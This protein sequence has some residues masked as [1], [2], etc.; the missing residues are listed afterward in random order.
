MLQDEVEGMI[1]RLRLELCDLGI[2]T[3]LPVTDLGTK[4]SMSW[5]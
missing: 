2:A 3:S 5:L 4:T 1:C